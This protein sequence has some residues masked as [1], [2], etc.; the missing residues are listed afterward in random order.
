ML[1]ESEKV[2]FLRCGRGHRW[3]PYMVMTVV[4]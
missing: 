4:G 1:N 2:G 3:I